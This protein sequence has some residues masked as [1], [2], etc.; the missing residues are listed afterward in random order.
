MYGYNVYICNILIKKRMTI[1]FHGKINNA[2]HICPTHLLRR[3]ARTS[4]GML[5]ST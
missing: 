2:W 4:A 1:P 5:S 3:C